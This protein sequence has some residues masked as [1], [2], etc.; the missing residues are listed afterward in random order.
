M[1]N[2]SKD[3]PLQKQI[4]QYIGPETT[5]SLTSTKKA[6]NVPQSVGY[7]ILNECTTPLLCDFN[8]EF[9]ILLRASFPHFWKQNSLKIILK[10]RININV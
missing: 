2:T 8:H 4:D 5:D 6:N 7:G 10:E 1:L 3:D 9:P